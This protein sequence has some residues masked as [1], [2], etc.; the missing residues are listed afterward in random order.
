V[1][2]T[3][4]VGTA[5]HR[6][7]LSV[8]SNAQFTASAAPTD[9]VGCAWEQSL[10]VDSEVFERGND[11]LG[12]ITAPLSVAAKA[13]LTGLLEKTRS[14]DP[15]LFPKRLAAEG[16]ANEDERRLFSSFA[17]PEAL[18]K[19]RNVREADTVLLLQ[20]VRCRQHDFPESGSESLKECLQMC[21]HALRDTAQGDA[22]HL[23][24]ALRSLADEL[25]PVAG[26]VTRAALVDRLRER[27]ALAEYP[28][29]RPD[30]AKLDMQSGVAATQ[31]P[32]AIAG[33]VTLAR[34]ADLASLR[35][36]LQDDAFVALVGASGGGKS[37]IARALFEARTAAGER[38]L[39]FDGRSFEQP[40]FNAF[41]ATL[42][43]KHS[44]SE[45]LATAAD[46]KP[47]L[48]LDGLDRIYSD[49]SFR[50]ASTLLRLARQTSPSTQW[51]VVAPCQTQEWPRVLEGMQRAGFAGGPWREIELKRPSTKDLSVVSEEIPVLGKLFLQPRVGRLLGN[52]KMLDLVA[53]RVSTGADLDA[54]TW[55]GES[56]VADWFWTAEVDRGMDRVARG[57]FVRKLAQLQADQQLAAVRVD[58]FPIGELAPLESLA[59]GREHR[60][61]RR[62]A[63]PL[64]A[65]TPVTTRTRHF[66][67][68]IRHHPCSW[69]APRRQHVSR[70]GRSLRAA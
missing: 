21:R 5:R 14:A 60:G 61:R 7:A 38:T 11:F 34:E 69:A 45:L 25:R 15:E 50:S 52:L 9:F 37:A 23:W 36:V 4:A 20:R 31:I 51:R 63:V 35:D 56:N 2:V 19:A 53:R 44:L 13:S 27:F 55:V 62:T 67:R 49:V 41:A 59:A 28:N 10:H 54:T 32:N 48:I 30:W 64:Q 26:S 33:R 22:E 58:D 65:C 17:C 1:L 43:L 47:T 16:W 68:R 18:A 40:D 46:F 12:M 39:W 57:S 24:N 6:F 42:R 3:T 70:V 8:K 29:H 66:R